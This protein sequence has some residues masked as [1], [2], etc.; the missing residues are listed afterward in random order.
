MVVRGVGRRAGTR[1]HTQR[2]YARELLSR[3]RAHGSDR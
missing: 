1:R 3:E 2:A